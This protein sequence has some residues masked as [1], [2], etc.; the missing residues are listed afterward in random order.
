M[1]AQALLIW[2]QAL[3]VKNEKGSQNNFNL[4]EHRYF[5]LFI[6]FEIF[7]YKKDK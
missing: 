6:V 2:K 1:R 7:N 4:D 5:S 3:K